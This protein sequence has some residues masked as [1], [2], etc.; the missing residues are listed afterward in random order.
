M[1]GIVQ[2]PK[3]ISVLPDLRLKTI[4]NVI[5]RSRIPVEDISRLMSSQV[6]ELEIS[7]QC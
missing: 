2:F 7:R 6:L 1:F 3:D 4:G 5:L